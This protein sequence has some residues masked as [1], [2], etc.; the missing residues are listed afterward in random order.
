MLAGNAGGQSRHTDTSTVS[1]TGRPVGCA[2]AAHH[3]RQSR[4][5][6]LQR[7]RL[8]VEFLGRRGALFGAGRRTLRDLLHLCDSLGH[9]LDATR[10]FLAALV[11]LVHQRLDLAELLGH[12]PNGRRHLIHLDLAVV[13]FGDGLLD[14]R[15]APPKPPGIPPR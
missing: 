4:H 12:G 8:R 9:L 15:N 2:V 6:G 10:L 5:D 14:Q 13:A 1:I 7:R 11:H 3:G